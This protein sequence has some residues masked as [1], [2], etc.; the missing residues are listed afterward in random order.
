MEALDCVH[1]D[2]L[3]NARATQGVGKLVENH[4]SDAHFLKLVFDLRQ[5]LLSFIAV[6][7]GDPQICE[8]LVVQPSFV[9]LR[10]ARREIENWTG[11]LVNS[12]S[13]WVPIPKVANKTSFP[14]VRVTTN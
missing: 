9:R 7:E 10:R 12:I 13:C 8:D 3:L 14:A 1:K 6:A 11:A 4:H 2:P 5:F